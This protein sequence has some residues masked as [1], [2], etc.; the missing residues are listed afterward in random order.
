MV[1]PLRRTSPTGKLLWRDLGRIS[2]IAI[3]ALATLMLAS[4]AVEAQSDATA[5]GNLTVEI[6]AANGVALNWDA[7]AEDS[8][9]VTGYQ[10]L[11]RVPLQ[12]E[13]R[14]TVY[15]A[16]TGS[17]A[18]TYTD[19]EAI[20]SG[21][22]YNYRVKALRGDQK[23]RMSNPATVTLPQVEPATTSELT[24]AT[25][26]ELIL[27]DANGTS[28]VLTP[29][30]D[31]LL[32][33][34]EAPV[35]NV[36]ASISVAATK[37]ES[38]ATLEFI[39]RVDAIQTGDTS[40]VEYTLAVGENLIEVEVTSASGNEVKTY[41]VTVTRAASDDATLGSL[42]LQDPNGTVVG[43]IPE[44]DPATT[45]YSV[46]VPNGVE[47]VTLTTEKSHAGALAT[48]LTPSGTSEPG[49]AA[50]VDLSVGSNVL[51]VMV[52]AEDGNAV[53]TYTV[54]VERAEPE[55]SA[56][57]TV[58]SLTVGTHVPT[59]PV[60]TGHTELA[61]TGS[62]LSTNEFTF[63]GENYR[64]K[65]L[66]YLAEGLYFTLDKELP[67]DFTLRIGGSDYAGRDSSIGR[68][69]WAGNYWWGDRGF[70]WTPGETVE[71]S[72]SMNLAPLPAREDAP[73][74]A[75]FTHMPDS[76]NGDDSFEF[77]LDFTQPVEITDVN[78][79]DHALEVDGGSVSNVEALQEHRWLITVE[80][81]SSDDVAVSL[82]E[83]ANCQEPGA[84]CSVG[85]KGLYNYP[86]LTVPGPVNTTNEGH[87]TT[88]Y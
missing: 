6:V 20:V 54:S 67:T 88:R 1:S 29:N 28:I 86:V 8:E 55:W 83:A 21:E 17:T 44:F 36:V 85:G 61:I 25:I 3:L 2:W 42:E 70:S 5:P 53:V 32:D 9:S 15:V 47:S 10:V 72:L 78:L 12:G 16:D 14:P 62:E 49:G 82:Y 37:N 11:R 34:Y 18:T 33:T 50:T 74:S 76:H 69:I 41:T 52:T 71:V 68:S 66:F 79:R 35:S 81:D 63:E 57:L 43:M 77:R 4:L 75:Y 26:N 59:V 46:S 30:F 84:I 56:S 22:Q 39:N 23:S 48:V 64:V 87:T 7:P 60:A 38:G 65:F 31:P 24:D 40:E 13:R 27:T 58:A 73:P 51:S 19:S 80:P 45:E